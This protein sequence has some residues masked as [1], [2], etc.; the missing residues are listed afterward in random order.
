[1]SELEEAVEARIAAYRPDD[2]PPFDQL[3]PRR[4]RGVGSAAAAVGVAALVAAVIVVPTRFGDD[5]RGGVGGPP[6]SAM[7]GMDRPRTAPPPA[8]APVTARAAYDRWKARGVPNYTM[9]F[10]RSCFCPRLGPVTVTVVS[11]RVVSPAGRDKAQVK[12]IDQL[13]TLILSG[14]ADRITVTYDPEFGYPRT[15]DAD[16]ILGAIDDE[17]RYRVSDYHPLPP[18]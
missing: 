3:P 8:P 5:G 7:V 6:P 2:T 10:S 11:G 14:E 12:T 18:P 1:M 15:V 16:M 4:R 13:F 9:R 17:V